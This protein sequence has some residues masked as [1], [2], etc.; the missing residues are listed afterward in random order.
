MPFHDRHDAQFN[1]L[2]TYY[3][4]HYAYY[5]ATQKTY[6]YEGAEECIPVILAKTGSIH[7]TALGCEEG[8]VLGVSRRRKYISI[9]R[10]YGYI[11]Q[12][13]VCTLGGMRLGGDGESKLHL[14]DSVRTSQKTPCVFNR[15]MNLL[16][17]YIQEKTLYRS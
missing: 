14:K 8:I 11:L 2:K 13:K 10:P 15:N 3:K 4:G 7:G 12:L 1:T 17:L 6:V 5:R 9:S 16:I